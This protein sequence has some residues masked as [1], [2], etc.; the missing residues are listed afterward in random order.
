[1]DAKAECKT[2]K[3]SIVRRCVHIDRNKHNTLCFV[4]HNVQEMSTRHPFKRT[5][6]NARGVVD[7]Y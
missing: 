3:G 2:S 6:T 5:T 1:M 4:D 7:D